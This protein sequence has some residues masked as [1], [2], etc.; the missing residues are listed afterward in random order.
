MKSCITEKSFQGH[1][2]TRGNIQKL[3][4]NSTALR[5]NFSL[6]GTKYAT[7]WSEISSI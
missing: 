6:H 3:A 1:T 7:Q 2:R 5:M 4:R